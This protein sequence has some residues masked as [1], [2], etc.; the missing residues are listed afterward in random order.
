MKFASLTRSTT[1]FSGYVNIP[2]RALFRKLFSLVW[3]LLRAERQ[4]LEELERCVRTA[5]SVYEIE[6]GL[7][8]VAPDVYMALEYLAAISEES[9]FK[10]YADDLIRLVEQEGY[11]THEGKFRITESNTHGRT[12]EH[13]PF[14][15]SVYASQFD[16]DALSLEFLLNGMN[17]PQ[18]LRDYLELKHSISAY[19]LSCELSPQDGR[20][21]CDVFELL[22]PIQ[23]VTGKS[24]DSRHAVEVLHNKFYVLWPIFD[25]TDLWYL[26]N[27]EILYAKCVKREG[28]TL[29]LEPVVI[30]GILHRPTVRIMIRRVL[31]VRV[32]DDVVFNPA[33]FIGSEMRYINT[34]FIDIIEMLQPLV[35]SFNSPQR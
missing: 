30:Q 2:N 15:C 34:L 17:I 7:A 13:Y 4:P 18:V 19:T 9:P 28:L 25:D 26:L 12:I 29:I 32:E 14:S 5:Q 16:R 27:I 20:Y 11:L 22:D 31:P 24:F 21:E 8:R 6:A 23:G 35:H 10:T 33:P 3:I 1:H